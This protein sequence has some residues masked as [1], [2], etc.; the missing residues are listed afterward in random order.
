MG[1]DITGLE[2]P[3]AKRFNGRTKEGLGMNSS[4]EQIIAAF[5]EPT[6]TKGKRGARESMKYEP[7]GI[8]F[9]LQAGKV[10]HMIVTL[11]GEDP[12]PNQ[13]DLPAVKLD[14]DTEPSA[15]KK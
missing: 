2:G 4:R 13:E 8:N 9:T 6:E 12:P 1:G 14:V 5:G 7:Q 11:R 3:Y 10:H 15:G